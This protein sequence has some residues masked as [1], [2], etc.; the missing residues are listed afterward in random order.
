MTLQIQPLWALEEM[1]PV[2]ALQRTYWGDEGEALVPVH[3]LFSLAAHGG[4]VLAATDGDAIAGVVMGMLGADNLHSDRPAAENL[5]VY[6]KRM[7]VS[8]DYRNQGLGARLKFAQREF[9]L[10]QGVHKIV[11]TFDPMLSPNAHLNVH[12]L[13]GMSRSYREDYYG[14][15]MAGLAP[16]GTSDRLYLEWMLDDAGVVARA[17]GS[18]QP[19][20]V[21]DYLDG[22]ALI[23]NP[24]G[25]MGDFVSPGPVLDVDGETVLVQI[26]TRY[27]A[28]LK[29][30]P[31]LAQR[32]RAHS[33]DT[34]GEWMRR[35]YVVRDFV[36]ITAETGHRFGFYV[37]QRDHPT[38]DKD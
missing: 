13:G 33:R 35:G 26:P 34:L 21:R 31:E 5:Y 20:T 8:R 12:K 24:A 18:W 27:A 9:A 29:D 3:M 11:W 16:D 36:S 10:A 38:Q 6:S 17:N 32:W 14:T 30:Q 22:G 28:M 1:A 4:H 37:L 7:I 19:L 15:A 23:I 25:P 2:E